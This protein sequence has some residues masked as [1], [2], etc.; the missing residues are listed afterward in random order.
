MF[1]LFALDSLDARVAVAVDHHVEDER[2]AT[3]RTILENALAPPAGRIDA[4]GVF[5]AAGRA[6]VENVEVEGHYG[7]SARA[8]TIPPNAATIPSSTLPATYKSEVSAKPF[9]ARSN[10]SYENVENVVYPPSTP[11]ARK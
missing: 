3:H 9:V 6:R 11:V 8:E 7:A 2:P 1:A 10:A 5:F 4:E